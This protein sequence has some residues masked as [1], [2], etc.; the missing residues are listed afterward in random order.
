MVTLLVIRTE[1]VLGTE[2]FASFHQHIATYLGNDTRYTEQI[3]MYH[4]NSKLS[5]LYMI[6]R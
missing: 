5:V 2:E 4:I 6:N 1:A 3:S